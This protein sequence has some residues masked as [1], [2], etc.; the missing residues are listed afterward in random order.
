[1]QSYGNIKGDSG[2]TGFEIK[3]DAILIEFNDGHRYLYN[4]A[5]TG[6]KNVETMKTLAESGRGLS[7]FVSRYVRDAYAAKF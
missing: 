4:Y 1:M 3:K 5:S 2:V 7:T 6:R